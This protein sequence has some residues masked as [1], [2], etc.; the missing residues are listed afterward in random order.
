MGFFSDLFGKKT[1]CLCG[2]ECGAMRVWCY[3]EGEDQEQ[4]IRL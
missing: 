2:A 1:C 4:G 3:E